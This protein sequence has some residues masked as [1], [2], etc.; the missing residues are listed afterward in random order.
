MSKYFDKNFSKDIGRDMRGAEI[1]QPN[2]DDNTSN[3][4]LINIK[5]G[6]SI[7]V[8]F[9]LITP[10]IKLNFI[11]ENN[12]SVVH[13]L[14]KTKNTEETK[15]SLLKFFLEHDA[16]LN[17]YNREK[18]TPLHIAILNG[19]SKIVNFLIDHK[20]NINAITNNN[21]NSLFL[22]LKNN[23]NVCPE[24][25]TPKEL[26]KDEKKDNNELFNL[27]KNEIVKGFQTNPTYNI[28]LNT[29]LKQIFKDFIEGRNY[30]KSKI[31]GIINQYKNILKNPESSS[32]NIRNKYDSELS[33]YV[34][35]L[36]SEFKNIDDNSNFDE[37][38]DFTNYNTVKDEER[39]KKNIDD[40]ENEIKEMYDNKV[41]ELQNIIQQISNYTVKYFYYFQYELL[42][43]SKF[44]PDLRNPNIFTLFSPDNIPANSLNINIY[45]YN[46]NTGA[47]NI[48][49]GSPF[50]F[51]MLDK[52]KLPILDNLFNNH[53][54][55]KG[56]DVEIINKFRNHFENLKKLFEIS[57][58]IDS[59]DI[60]SF[61]YNSPIISYK[62]I[63]L[64]YSKIC[65]IINIIQN[66]KNTF[67]A[68]SLEKGSENKRNNQYLHRTENF[69]IYNF[70]E[71]PV[72]LP[73]IVGPAVQILFMLPIPAP[74]NNFI[75]NIVNYLSNVDVA[76]SDISNF[77][78]SNDNC[79]SIELIEKLNAINTNKYTLKFIDILNRNT[80]NNIY[81]DIKYFNTLITAN[82][83]NDHLQDFAIN[84]KSQL[85][86]AR[87][88]VNVVLS[89][90]PLHII[91]AI[92]DVIGNPE[93]DLNSVNNKKFKLFKDSVIPTELQKILEFNKSYEN[94]DNY[95]KRNDKC[96]LLTVN[97]D[98]IIIL[99]KL[100][101]K[102]L[103]KIINPT[104][105]TIN[106]EIKKYN[107]GNLNEDEFKS[108]IASFINNFIDQYIDSA[109]VNYSRDLLNEK[110]ITFDDIKLQNYD[111]FKDI[112]ILD[113]V[114]KISSKD[115]RK[116]KTIFLD[117]SY[118]LKNQF[119][120][121][122]YNSNDEK[123]LCYN[124]N[125]TIIK[126]LLDNSQT[127]Y[128]DVDRDGNNILHYLVNI[129][130]YKFFNEIYN[131]REEKLK[132]F[133]NTKNKFNIS[134]IDSIKNKIEKNIK[135]FYIIT[136]DKVDEDKL[137][138]STIFSSNLFTKLKNTNEINGLIPHFMKDIFDDIFVIYNLTNSSNLSEDIFSNKISE[139][140]TKITTNG[141]I[142]HS[143]DQ[144]FNNSNNK[145]II[146]YNKTISKWRIRDLSNVDINISDKLYK[147]IQ[148]KHNSIKDISVNKYFERFWNTIAHTITLHFS[149]VFYDMIYDLYNENKDKLIGVPIPTLAP[150][151]GA[152]VAPSV[153]EI[154]KKFK[155][156]VFNFD[157]KYEKRNLAQDII[158]NIYKIKYSSKIRDD[159]K[160][161]SDLDSILKF[162][163]T[164]LINLNSKDRN[165][166]YNQQI[167][168]I[169]LTLKAMFDVFN[170]EIII[171]LTSYIKFIELQYHLQHIQKII[172]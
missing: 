137:L 162:K 122:N 26:N 51:H 97:K 128:F 166:S 11:D 37:N 148:E 159:D 54:L 61:I 140:K 69:M 135:N 23:V 100:I 58:F 164:D 115:Y 146:N 17:T 7:K 80:N 105:P 18:L 95:I 55:N 72:P 33:K 1:F 109:K 125:V 84:Y 76:V 50:N 96:K 151:P 34:E 79:K 113:V 13:L 121:Y 21:L 52:T 57:S 62:F 87:G 22:A 114:G 29:H 169:I 5:S 133:K 132:K 157:S 120:N 25:I 112:N 131:N 118:K 74:G 93:Y 142:I 126:K 41:N 83:K 32:D 16:P 56:Y 170:K 35:S 28:F 123:L 124:N 92:D 60:K 104:N 3:L 171:F 106:V 165:I 127:N 39:I 53:I 86:K 108:I 67:N 68:V 64:N 88:D 45:N 143:Y 149:T 147:F 43:L 27:I 141:G 129:E 119:Y 4:I 152:R 130:N 168:K 6:D 160:V 98:P 138:F 46:I 48:I 150:G 163:L 116:K 154:L 78:L 66:I 70:Y 161:F 144:L 47:I 40:T 31:D 110:N 9:Q 8:L 90:N 91:S 10:E 2:I 156:S 103:I 102:E 30:E 167:E 36:K 81:Y 77:S 158:L 71:N 99:K 134:P 75:D 136:K 15:I 139:I 49:A 59:I 65:Q 12:N 89:G 24:L 19:E 94:G 42:L 63:L 155:D 38:E 101:I 20:V 73:P 117:E 44:N 107:P 145:K 85:Y 111:L 14:L 153:D 172:L 82:D